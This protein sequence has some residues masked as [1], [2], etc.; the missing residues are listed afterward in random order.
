ME[1]EKKRA[2]KKVS[3]FRHPLVTDKL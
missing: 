3:F 2:V 1:S